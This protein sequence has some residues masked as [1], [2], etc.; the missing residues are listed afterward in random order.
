VTPVCHQAGPV[1]ANGFQLCTR[2]GLVMSEP[3]FGKWP[4]FARVALWDDGHARQWVLMG[5]DEPLT[6]AVLS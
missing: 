6:C 5:H 2:C 3:G 1:D 4:D